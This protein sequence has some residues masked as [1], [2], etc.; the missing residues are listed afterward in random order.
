[1][2]VTVAKSVLLS[3]LSKDGRYCSDGNLRGACFVG[4]LAQMGEEVSLDE[5]ASWFD[6][7]VETGQVSIACKGCAPDWQRQCVT[8][9]Y[10]YAHQLHGAIE[11]ESCNGLGKFPESP[12]GCYCGECGM[13]GYR[14][15][16][17]NGHERR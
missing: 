12:N 16:A 11:C 8:R 6:V 17:S 14:N 13:T 10:F 1:M 2:T 15:V 7:H 3:S 4:F 9:T 5:L